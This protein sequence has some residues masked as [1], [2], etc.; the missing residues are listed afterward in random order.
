MATF[1]EAQIRAALRTVIANAAPN[2]VIFPWWVLGHDPNQWP[3]VLK[4][5][6]GPDVNKVH[7]YVFTRT[8]TEAERRNSQCVR[9]VFTYDIWGFYF[10]DE[11]SN[12]SSSSDVRF[13]AELDAINDSFIAPATLSPELQ[14]V[15]QEPQFSVDLEVFGGELLH[16]AR[17]QLIVQQIGTT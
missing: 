15:M 7:G 2:A 13:N 16:F 1:T 8:L 11:T 10:Y 4:P 5:S 14:R 12:N 9:R 3:G 17:G 6:S